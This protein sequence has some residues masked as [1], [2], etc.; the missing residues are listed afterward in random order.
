MPYALVAIYRV[1]PGAEDAVE[2]ALRKMTEHTRA[3][4]GCLLYTPHRSPED[5]NV[6]FLYECYR[7]E[8][9]FHEHTSS[10]HFGRH[11]KN[12][13]WPQVEE[14]TRILGTPLA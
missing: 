12:E 10:D 13:V 9:A 3:E 8:A 11:I 14:R 7:D 1:K 6:F 4:P 5:G 2:E